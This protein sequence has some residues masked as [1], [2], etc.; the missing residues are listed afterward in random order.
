MKKKV[1]FGILFCFIWVC[2]Q[3]PAFA[4]EQDTGGNVVEVSDAREFYEAL[5][6]QILEHKDI[7]IYHTYESVFKKDLQE[8]FDNY[9]FH[10]NADEPR[11]SGSYL[12][13]YVKSWG[14]TT[15]WR[16]SFPGGYNCRIEVQPEY[17]H[18]KGEMDEY[19]QAIK[20]LAPTLKGESDYESVKAVHD[21]LIEHYDY[22]DQYQNYLDYE[23]YV[24]GTMVCQGYCMAA[25]LL[26]SEMDV[27]V[28]IVIGAA[29]DYEKDPDHAWNVVKVDGQWYNMD[30]T[31][32]DPGGKKPK[33]TYF[34]KNDA[35][36]YKHTREGYYDY[37]RDM[38]V[39]SYRM[40]KKQ[41]IEILLIVLIICVLFV[42]VLLLRARRRKDGIWMEE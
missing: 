15:A 13:W 31:W 33:Y 39:L 10:Y 2:C 11:S 1:I 41:G 7:V 17:K 4:K 25:Y 37:D 40:P 24:N 29:E 38:A 20:E 23:G 36:F 34:L 16:G 28:R 32:D 3:E 19:F 22:D 30:V 26:L 9:A 35:D 5:S 18:S 12:Y 27:P 8:L 6:R 21:Y 14:K 42:V